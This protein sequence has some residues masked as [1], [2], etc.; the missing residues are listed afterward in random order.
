MQPP[1]PGW[2][3]P[4]PAS[5][6][7]VPPGYLPTGPYP[8]GQPAWP[9]PPAF[10]A[11]PGSVPQSWATTTT[12]PW[13]S[14]PEEPLAPPRRR[15][16]VIAAMV[17]AALLLLGGGGAALAVALSGAGP[18]TAEEQAVVGKC[19]SVSGDAV[20]FADCSAAHGGTV[21]SVVAKYTDCPAGTKAF[22]LHP[23]T[24]NE[25]SGCYKE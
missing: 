19:L 7:P 4:P 15:R 17:I 25:H 24:N 13:P 2:P 18:V 3:P 16:G 11:Q 23:N 8:G 6:E 12:H 22:R 14:G 9:G 10:P 20:T 21:T 1:P 5:P